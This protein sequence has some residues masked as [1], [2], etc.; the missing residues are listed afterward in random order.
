MI[1]VVLSRYPWPPCFSKIQSAI[2]RISFLLSSKRLVSQRILLTTK[3]SQWSCVTWMQ[4]STKT[5]TVRSPIM[6]SQMSTVSQTLKPTSRVKTRR[7]S[8]DCTTIGCSGMALTRRIWWVF[9]WRDLRLSHLMPVTVA[10]YSA[11]QFILRICSASRCL[12]LL[13]TEEGRIMRITRSIC[14]CVK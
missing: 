2:S 13:I 11:M 10:R 1:S 4:A 8:T 14:C 9:W 5:R 12:I 3:S 7:S 6:S